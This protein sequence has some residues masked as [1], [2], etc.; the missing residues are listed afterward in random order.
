MPPEGSKPIEALLRRYAEHRATNSG[1]PRE[2]HPANR[3][4]LQ[5]EVARQY[6]SARAAGQPSWATILGAFARRFAYVGV[7]AALAALAAVWIWISLGPQTGQPG[8]LA[9]NDRLPVTRQPGLL[10]PLGGRATSRPSL[11]LASSAQP[12]LSLAKGDR[13]GGTPDLVNAPVPARTRVSAVERS[14]R[15]DSD[16]ASLGRGSFS[17]IAMDA[18]TGVNRA[19]AVPERARAVSEAEG[20]ANKESNLDAVAL[21]AAAPP[22]PPPAPAPVVAVVPQSQG[23]LLPLAQTPANQASTYQY[24]LGQPATDPSAASVKRDLMLSDAFREQKAETAKLGEPDRST[25]GGLVGGGGRGGRMGGFG[26]DG[27]GLGG[28]GILAPAAK[29][30]DGL[31]VNGYAVTN[32]LALSGSVSGAAG[33]SMSSR[34]Y[35]QIETPGS[36]RPTAAAALVQT[37]TAKM[38]P[39]GS[40]TTSQ[41]GV[42]FARMSS[43]PESAL[44]KE[45]SAKAALLTQFE[46]QRQ[47]E[48]IQ[49]VDSDGSAYAGTLLS[50][51][52]DLRSRAVQIRRKSFQASRGADL[53]DK[54]LT[55]KPPEPQMAAWI[56]GTLEFQVSG[57]NRSSGQR[58][59]LRGTLTGDAGRQTAPADEGQIFLAQDV[60]SNEARQT[61]PASQISPGLAPAPANSA[62]TQTS[63]AAFAAATTGNMTER[64]AGTRPPEML[65]LEGKL[66]VGDGPEQPFQAFRRAP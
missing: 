36:S 14:L 35:R 29:P 62:P 45:K 39:S 61:G 53:A 21:L 44:T 63:R 50:G 2:L 28:L 34:A 10:E 37:A 55:E 49:I 42:F 51:P 46:I 9:R 23:E 40:A 17:G 58:V 4:L 5:G 11:V 19:K 57:T 31:A 1:S 27:G 18:E 3:R 26:G 54:K 8:V 56:A 65:R 6:A 41:P 13:N 64:I 60:R 43:T 25:L 52:E 12:S 30:M 66:R 32:G 48:R 59:V 20:I 38:L 24:R 15:V 33:D 16:A 7:S 47:G 22:A